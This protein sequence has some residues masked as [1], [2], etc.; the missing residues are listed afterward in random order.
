MSILDAVL[1]LAS[2]GRTV[3]FT[4]GEHSLTVDIRDKRGASLSRMLNWKHV[5][6]HREDPDKIF[7]EWLEFVYRDW[8]YNR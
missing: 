6:K 8:I 2:T 5:Y 1:S 4:R 7:E 3:T